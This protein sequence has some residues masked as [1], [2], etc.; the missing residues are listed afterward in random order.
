[1]HVSEL[2]C[3]RG[4]EL[5]LFFRRRFG[6]YWRHHLAVNN[7]VRH[8]ER[9]RKPDL[10]RLTLVRAEDYARGLGFIPVMEQPHYRASFRAKLARG[11]RASASLVAQSTVPE[12]WSI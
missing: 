6:R 1:M 8:I 2:T 9:W 3:E 4:R 10:H 12:D 5:E 11:K 7:I